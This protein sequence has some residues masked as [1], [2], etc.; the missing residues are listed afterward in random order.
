MLCGPLCKSRDIFPVGG[1]D[2]GQIYLCKNCKYRGTFV[3]EIDDEP[4]NP[5]GA[6]GNNSKK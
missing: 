5:E 1:G 2:L 4:E 6:A 3:L